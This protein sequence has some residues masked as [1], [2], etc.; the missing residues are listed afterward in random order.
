MVE[1]TT[2]VIFRKKFTVHL[3]GKVGLLDT[4]ML[5]DYQYYSYIKV[6]KNPTRS[7]RCMLNSVIKI[8]A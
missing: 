4:R 8:I 3:Q 6:Q 1:L 7:S 5:L 2:G